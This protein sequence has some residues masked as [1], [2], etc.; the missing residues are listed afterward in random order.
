MMESDSFFAWCLIRTDAVLHK[1]EPV[2]LDS[3]FIDFLLLLNVWGVIDQI[4]KGISP[5]NLSLNFRQ[6]IQ[7]LIQG[8]EN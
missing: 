5:K 8:S 6:K 1:K 3:F 4:R 7:E 2:M